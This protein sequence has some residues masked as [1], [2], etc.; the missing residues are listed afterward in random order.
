MHKKENV[1][2]YLIVYAFLV[3]ANTM[4]SYTSKSPRHWREHQLLLLN[5]SSICRF[6]KARIKADASF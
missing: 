2:N 4:H 5:A 1:D 3:S 6:R